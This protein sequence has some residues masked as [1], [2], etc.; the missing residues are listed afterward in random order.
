M[1]LPTMYSFK[2]PPHELA[3]MDCTT[4][5]LVPWNLNDPYGGTANSGGPIGPCWKTSFDGRD[6]FWDSFG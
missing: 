4:L 1:G 5:D 6:I 2:M 3:R